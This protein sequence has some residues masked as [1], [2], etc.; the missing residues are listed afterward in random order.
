MGG[1]AMTLELNQEERE[2]LKHALQVYLGDLREEIV[3]TESHHAKPPL[4]REEEVIKA[5]LQRLSS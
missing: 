1:E 5:I 4:K 3:K 2:I